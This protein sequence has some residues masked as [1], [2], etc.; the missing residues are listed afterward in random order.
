MKLPV[1][2]SAVVLGK[3]GHHPAD[4]GQVVQ[5]RQQHKTQIKS[6]T[7]LCMVFTYSTRLA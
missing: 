5:R 6:P 7:I 2:C 1:A 4:G 3:R